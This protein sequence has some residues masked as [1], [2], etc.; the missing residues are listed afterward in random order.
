MTR[1]VRVLVSVLT[2]ILLAACGSSSSQSTASPSSLSS[3]CQSIRTQY[4][5]LPKQLTVAVSPFNSHLEMIDPAN[6]NSIIGV[7]P[8]LIT[9]I[10][11]CL[12]FTFT[13]QSEAFAA[14]IASLTSGG[15]QLGITGLFITPARTKVI[16]LVSHM[17]SV[18]QVYTTP[19]L[20]PQL[21]VPLD[22]CGK[23][24]GETVGTAEATYVQN[25]ST[26]CVSGG[27]SAIQQLQYPDIASLFVNLANGNT[28]VTINSDT[29][30]AQVLQQYTGKIVT[31]FL[32]TD[33]S[34]SIGIGIGKSTA[35]TGLPDAVNAAV[36]WLQDSGADVKILTKWGFPASSLVPAQLYSS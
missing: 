12:G 23:K 2:G 33:L 28:D 5:N 34:Y 16:D 22:L 15:A 9:A 17:A 30:A 31:G 18:D 27:K 24:I 1:T 13:Y 10:S 35:S 8:D 25:L 36:K 4:P 32:V 3:Q 26:Q 6:P 20:G 11:N 29:L 19:S 14:V 21:K 7:E